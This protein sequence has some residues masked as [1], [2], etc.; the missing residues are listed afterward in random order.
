MVWKLVKDSKKQKDV[1]QEQ[2]WRCDACN[3]LICYLQWY[4]DSVVNP[5][6]SE[7]GNDGEEDSETFR[8]L[9]PK[10]RSECT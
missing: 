1:V 3:I 7:C 8:V 10:C 5:I 2:E 9:C 4:D 6:C